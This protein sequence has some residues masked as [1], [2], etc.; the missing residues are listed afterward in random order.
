LNCA[1]GTFA[2]HESFRRKHQAESVERG[3]WSV[4]RRA[5]RRAWS[6]GLMGGYLLRQRNFNFLSPTLHVG[7]SWPSGTHGLAAIYCNLKVFGFHGQEEI[8][9]K[10][11]MS[12]D[13]LK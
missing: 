13:G 4:E 12:Q 9:I 11:L 6:M 5:Y 8:C 1:S 10:V 7:S 3:A 2:R